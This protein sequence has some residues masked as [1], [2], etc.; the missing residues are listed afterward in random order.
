MTLEALPAVT[1]VG[2]SAVGLPLGQPNNNKEAA[3]RP[4]HFNHWNEPRLVT[5]AENFGVVIIGFREVTR[6][7]RLSPPTVMARL[8]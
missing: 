4:E 5:T 1:L 2:A 3:S 8:I 6:R 7:L